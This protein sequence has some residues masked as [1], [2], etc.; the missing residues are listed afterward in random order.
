[1][2]SPERPE[3]PSPP[4]APASSELPAP[5]HAH[6]WWVVNAWS[7]T[8]ELATVGAVCSICG[9]VEARP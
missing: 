6:Q 2:N 3:R 5:D 8:G 4:I 7:S 1:M 9:L